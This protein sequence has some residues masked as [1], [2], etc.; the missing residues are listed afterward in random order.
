MGISKSIRDGHHCIYYRWASLFI[1]EMGIMLY[2][3]EIGIIVSIR[4][5]IIVYIRNGDHC[6][7]QRWASLCINLPWDHARSQTK[8]GPDRFS[9]FDVYWILKQTEQA[10][11][12][13]MKYIL[14]ILTFLFIIP[15]YKNLTFLKCK[16]LCFLWYSKCIFKSNQ[17]L[18][19]LK[20][21]F[22]S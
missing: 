19:I 8:V 17:K 3:F 18:P 9:C 13:G 4:D 14:S 7:Y 12:V 20:N 6:I 5:C 11:T 15:R 21:G 1:L 22:Y 2:I 10:R 16:R